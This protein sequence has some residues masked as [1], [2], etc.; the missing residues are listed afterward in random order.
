MV[1]DNL[2]IPAQ[3]KHQMEMW[4]AYSPM[5]SDYTDRGLPQLIETP[6][7]KRLA[8]MIDP[9]AY[10]SRIKAPTLMVNGAN[11]P[12]WTV[13]ALSIYWKDLK[14][15]KWATIAGGRPYGQRRPRRLRALLF[16]RVQVPFRRYE[17]FAERRPVTGRRLVGG[18][19][20]RRGE[21]MEGGV[22][23]FS[24]RALQMVRDRTVLLAQRR[25]P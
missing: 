19:Q 25:R 20:A 13:D 24:V 17:R 14:Q 12:Y 1:Y 18:R 2:N 5:I 7:G 9:Y 4:N 15:S 16:G 23:R 6:E 22:A 10:R 11:D 21:A 3:L 8:G